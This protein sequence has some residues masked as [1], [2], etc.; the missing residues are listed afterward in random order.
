MTAL[1]FVV[2]GR[3]AGQGSK[4]VYGPGRVVESSKHVKPWREAVKAAALVAMTEQGLARF[5]GP[6]HVTLGVFFKRPR[7]HYRTGRFAH[8]LRENAP[9]WMTGTPDADKIARATLDALTDSG[10]FV[11]D[12]QVAWLTVMKHWESPELPFEGARIEVHP[13]SQEW[14]P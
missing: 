14:T 11:D 5:D 2:H 4:K 3:P 10:V 7:H 12:R 9:N 1:A 8:L 13:M 6:V